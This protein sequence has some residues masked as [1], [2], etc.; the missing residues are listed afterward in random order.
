MYTINHKQ[1]KQIE[2]SFI[3]FGQAFL[4]RGIIYVKA[5]SYQGFYHNAVPLAQKGEKLKPV[6]GFYGTEVVTPVYIIN[7]EAEY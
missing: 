3:G 7:I 2:F 4:Y 5:T 1:P 6:E